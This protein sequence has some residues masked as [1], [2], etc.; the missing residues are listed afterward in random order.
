MNGPAPREL[1]NGSSLKNEMQVDTIPVR[2]TDLDKCYDSC[3]YLYMNARLYCC[4]PVFQRDSDHDLL[5][6][7]CDTNDDEYV[8]RFSFI[9]SII[10]SYYNGVPLYKQHLAIR[11]FVTYVTSSVTYAIVVLSI[12]QY[13]KRSSVVNDPA[14]NEYEREFIEK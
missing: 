1:T 2:F 6:D 3:Y 13:H 8:C 11:Y 14:P 5:G 4:L 9:S 7:L 10:T 12:A